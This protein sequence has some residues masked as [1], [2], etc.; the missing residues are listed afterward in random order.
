MCR[1]LK[2]VARPS[3]QVS[4][5][6]LQHSDRTAFRR[7]I[8]GLI[9][10][11]SSLARLVRQGERPLEGALL[12]LP[13]QESVLLGDGERGQIIRIGN[14]CLCV[15]GYFVVQQMVHALVSSLQTANWKEIKLSLM[16]VRTPPHQSGG[17]P[18]RRPLGRAPG[19]KMKRTENGIPFLPLFSQSIHAPLPTD[20]YITPST[21][22]RPLNF[23]CEKRREV[24]TRKM[25]RREE[26]ERRRS[27]HVDCLPT[28]IRPPSV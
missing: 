1:H 8:D 14:K 16:S 24:A 12:A 18:N 15:S 26:K 17:C 7:A 10:L 11:P 2:K 21:S 4:R 9:W 22:A 6:V 27:T 25:E 5:S 19:L 23:G 13:E 28:S 3:R 20:S